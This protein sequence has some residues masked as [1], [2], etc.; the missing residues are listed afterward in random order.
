MTVEWPPSSLA[1]LGLINSVLIT[2]FDTFANCRYQLNKF[3]TSDCISCIF[4]LP[5]SHLLFHIFF[6]RIVLADIIMNLASFIIF[7]FALASTASAY[8]MPSQKFTSQVPGLGSV[9]GSDCRRLARYMAFL[10]MPLG[11]VP[12]DGTFL[13][14][15]LLECFELIIFVFLFQKMFVDVWKA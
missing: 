3:Q 4:F 2:F 8:L 9:I 15:K 14:R 11:K 5:S 1:S 10:G 7:C 12:T 6:Y 13:T